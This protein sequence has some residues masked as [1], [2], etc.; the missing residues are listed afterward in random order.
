MKDYGEKLLD[1]L[2]LSQ[3]IQMGSIET[4]LFGN[5]EEGKLVTG[6]EIED[7]G[8]QPRQ[9]PLIFDTPSGVK[10]IVLY[11][12]IGRHRYQPVTVV[13]TT[14]YV[15]VVGPNGEYLQAQV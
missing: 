4:I 9:I 7:F 13:V 12:S 10:K 15:E 3:K 5:A 2:Q 8:E 1:A 14:P 11:N 6:S